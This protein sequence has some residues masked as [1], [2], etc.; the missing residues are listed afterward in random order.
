MS[1]AEFVQ[2]TVDNH[3][4]LIT[5]NRPEALNA[6]NLSMIR[7][8]TQHL[9][10][11]SED[12]NI[13]AVVVKAVPGKAFCAGGDVRWIASLDSLD[14]QLQFFAEEYRLNQLIHDY[15]KPYIALMDGITMGGGVGISLHGRYPLATEKFM[16]AMPETRIGFFPDIGASY[17]L[18]RCP[19]HW[20]VYLGLTGARI[21]AETAQ[22]LGLVYGV[23]PASAQEDILQ[24]LRQM[25]E[26]ANIDTL[27]TPFLKPIHNKLKPLDPC[28]AKATIQ[29]IITCHPMPDKCPLSLKIT[30]EQLKR[31]KNLT[32]SECLKIDYQLVQ[33]FMQD[34][35]F[36]EGIRALLIDKDNNPQ[37][38]PS[39]LED[40]SEGG[41]FYQNFYINASF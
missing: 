41:S 12:A 7:T 24:C 1:D 14:K 20:G 2:C 30:F 28:F 5:L 13:Y 4:G 3:I 32:L 16:F 21:D 25:P 27:L 15:K 23:I 40:V 10:H 26:Q 17:L 6:L 33:K 11:W 19:D 22:Q 9:I 36:Y 34:P 29:E 38:Q 35:N 37:W 31:S 18:S 8:I 39:R